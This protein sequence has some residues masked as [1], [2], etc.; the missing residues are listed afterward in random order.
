MAIEWVVIGG[1]VVVPIIIAMLTG[2]KGPTPAPAPPGSPVPPAPSPSPPPVPPPV[3]PP[4]SPPP[5]PPPPPLVVSVYNQLAND[6]SWWQITLYS[7]GSYGVAFIPPAQYAARNIT[8][9]TVT[10]YMQTRGYTQDQINAALRA[11]FGIPIPVSSDEWRGLWP[12]AIVV[13]E[14]S[15]L[16]TLQLQFEH[17]G[18]GGQFVLGAAIYE[19]L[20]FNP[21]YGEL[22]GH[23]ENWYQI[24]NDPDWVLY[25]PFDLGTVQLNRMLFG[26]TPYNLFAEVFDGHANQWL[27]QQWA[28]SAFQ[29]CGGVAG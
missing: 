6:W 3:P 22:V 29:L 14:Q 19:R 17:R 18:P 28:F 16:I 13:N 21:P 9:E 27:A 10:Y 4:S 26:C 2:K 15:E 23:I 12:W 11:D 5:N 8:P 24:N 25:G 7:D 20:V 1:M